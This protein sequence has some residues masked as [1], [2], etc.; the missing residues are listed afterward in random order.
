MHQTDKIAIAARLRQAR[1][2]AGFTEREI[3]ELLDPPL[4]DR[5]IRTYEKDNPQMRYLRQWADITQVPYDWLLRGET[6]DHP[7]E[8]DLRAELETIRRSLQRLED[9]LAP[10]DPGS[11]QVG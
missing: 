4:T 11:A 8:P 9:L 1:E 6:A 5:S 3:G 10:P 7:T 2:Q